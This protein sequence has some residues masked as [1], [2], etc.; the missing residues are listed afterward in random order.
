ANTNT[1]IG[2]RAS[3]HLTRMSIASANPRNRVAVGMRTARARRDSATPKTTAN[4]IIGSIAPS[5]AALIGFA[6][7]NATS[8]LENPGSVGCGADDALD[9]SD[10]AD[11]GSMCSQPTTIG[12]TTIPS[13]A[14]PA[15]IATN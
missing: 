12:P 8:Q 15:S 9:R 4:T 5:A 3:T 7:T 10:A 2:A 11:A 13:T 1:P 6:G 14:T